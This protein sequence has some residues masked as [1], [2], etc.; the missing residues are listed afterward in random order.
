MSLIFYGPKSYY[1]SKKY[2]TELLF[3]FVIIIIYTCLY[4]IC[5]QNSRTKSVQYVPKIQG[6]CVGT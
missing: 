6:C 1:I 3:I 2:D 5:E 4:E